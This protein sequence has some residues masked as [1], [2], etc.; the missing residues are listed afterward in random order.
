[1]F[2]RLHCRGITAQ[3]GC[4]GRV[5]PSGRGEG[6]GL[7]IIP[8]STTTLS[9]DQ[10]STMMQV[11]LYLSTLVVR[12]ALALTSAV[13]LT[14]TKP[15]KIPRGVGAEE[16]VQ[17]RRE[18]E[19]FSESKALESIFLPACPRLHLKAFPLACLTLSELDFDDRHLFEVLNADLSSLRTVDLTSCE[20][21]GTQE[22]PVNWNLI[23]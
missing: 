22:D 10:L 17:D 16:E 4:Q 13:Y 20:S 3:H 2:G 21:T 14:S 12:P 7:M 5:I 1:M 9:D 23:S 19:L 18:Y 8:E 15:C 6:L 11:L